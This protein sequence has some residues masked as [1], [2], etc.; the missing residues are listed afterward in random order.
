MRVT[1]AGGDTL[2]D[3]IERLLEKASQRKSRYR[4][5]GRPRRALYAPIVHLDRRADRDRLADRRRV[6]CMTP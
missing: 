2:I 5:A 3:E 4:A 1:A 6:G